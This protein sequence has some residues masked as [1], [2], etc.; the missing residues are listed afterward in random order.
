[1][2]DE[3]PIVG[4]EDLLFLPLQNKDNR[5]KL[6]LKKKLNGVEWRHQSKHL[7]TQENHFKRRWRRSRSGG[8]G[9][10]GGGS[11]Q[12]GDLFVN[13]H[14]TMTMLLSDNQQQDGTTRNKQINSLAIRPPADETLLRRCPPVLTAVEQHRL[15]R[16]LKQ[17]RN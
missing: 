9:V 7:H 16:L 11:K 10:G 1:M 17:K 6:L 8:W 2:A 13:D 3:W 4:I 12:S 15:F 14:S 5:R